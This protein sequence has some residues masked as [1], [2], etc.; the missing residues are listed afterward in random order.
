MALAI[1]GGVSLIGGVWVAGIWYI[2]IGLFLRSTSRASYREML[3]RGALE[4]E[5]VSRFMQQAPA[6]V[7][8]ETPVDE[9]V[10]EF[11]FK[12]KEKMVP[13]GDDGHLLGCVTLQEIK[14]LAR[15]DWPRRTAGELAKRCSEANSI[16]P[17][18]GA[19]EALGRMQDS[20]NSDLL[21]VED[22]RLIGTIALRDMLRFLSLKM[23]LEAS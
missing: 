9:L 4:G 19:L 14:K 6:S 10:R 13:V 16:G 17:D 21:V 2:L 23:E 11:V 7:P 8:P 22:G 12:Q 3:L 18:A 20:K 5:P 15:S 1:L